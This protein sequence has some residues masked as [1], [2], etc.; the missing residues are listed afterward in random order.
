MQGLSL[1]GGYSARCSTSTQPRSLPP[2]RENPRPQ[3]PADLTRS[4]TDTTDGPGEP[5]V[6]FPETNGSRPET[7]PAARSAKSTPG[8][9]PT[10]PPLAPSNIPSPATS[11]GAM[12]SSAGAVPA[13]MHAR[14]LEFQK[15]RQRANS[16]ASSRD[17]SS[18]VPGSPG[19]FGVLSRS[20]SSSSSQSQSSVKQSPR[21]GPQGAEIQ[22]NGHANQQQ[23]QQQHKNDQ[24][25]QQQNQNQQQNQQYQHQH[26]QNQYQQAQGQYPP[27]TAQKT[28]AEAPKQ[29]SGALYST[30]GAK[31]QPKK[32]SLSQR[33][34][35]KLPGVDGGSN[36]APGG[37][38][39]TLGARGG[40]RGGPGPLGE[41]FPTRPAV[42]RRG[43]GASGPPP[44]IITSGGAGLF[45]SY[46]KYIDIKS[47]SLNFAGKASLHSKGIDFSSGS[48]F[49][50]SLAELEPMGELGRGNY[51]TVT[52][53]LHKPTNVIMAMK[54]IRL[55]LDET[56][57][58]QIIMELDIL[59]KCISPYIVDFY[60]A[61]FVEGAVYVCMEW[62]DGGSLNKIYEN[63]IDEPY[64]A[65]ITRA[66][67]TGLKELKEKHNIIHRDVKPTNIL[68]ST[69]GK[70]KL[71]DFGVSGRLVA[72]IARTNIGCQSYMA[73]ERIIPPEGPRDP[74]KAVTYTVESDVWSLGLSILEVASGAY[75]YPADTYR[76]ILSQINAIVAGNPPTLPADRFSPEA[77]SFVNAC[78]NKVPSLR[79]SY[80]ELLEHPWLNKYDPEEVQ[81]G[82]FVK[83]R[84][85]SLASRPSSGSSKPSP[86]LHSGGY[87]DVAN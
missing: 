52:K 17:H 42:D 21:L 75:P 10:S 55:E 30:M 24:Q 86:P 47:G 18:P 11:A 20:S 9:Q 76:T 48:S 44:S 33:R 37:N 36:T 54:E 22:Q 71:C 79:P 56:K 57:F 13:D 28:P 65:V 87:T 85:A 3:T 32:P 70:V 62:M 69:S 80:A 73:P 1:N 41:P 6:E 81:L 74:N 46:R 31:L 67:V 26:Q 38:T 78:L 25:S 19:T 35:M 84:L 7:A 34:G 8:V 14:I 4:K 77:I 63:G 61:F 51:G 16:G 15:S 2:M 12:L 39:P 40:A 50:I 72:S 49:R 59:H 27:A 82:N 58:T 64:L 60:G 23:D 68:T 83:D 29:F 45:N 43:M 53:V 5:S 66:V